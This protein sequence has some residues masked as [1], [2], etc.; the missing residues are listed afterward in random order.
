MRPRLNATWIRAALAVAVM[1]L[2]FGRVAVRDLPPTTWAV[3]LVPGESIDGWTVRELRRNPAQV[4]VDLSR[5]DNTRASLR[6]MHAASSPEGTRA[7]RYRIQAEV[8]APPSLVAEAAVRVTAWESE[9]PRPPAFVRA[10]GAQPS[11]TQRVEIILLDL[12]LAALV[13]VFVLLVPHL[14]RHAFLATP[15]RGAAL[16]ALAAVPGLLS[17]AFGTRGIWHSNH[18]GLDRWADLIA[19]THPAMA[20]LSLLH[21]GSFYLLHQLVPV[22]DPFHAATAL[23]GVAVVL[24][25]LWARALWDSDAAGL[26]AAALLAAAPLLVRVA[27]SE[28][29]YVPALA[30]LSATLLLTELWRRDARFAWGLLPALLLL[31]QSRGEML[32]LG[33]AFVGWCALARPPRWLRG[34]RDLLRPAVWAPPLL[35]G[36]ASIPRLM[37]FLDQPKRPNFSHAQD[38]VD[39]R[40]L[41][42]LGLGVAALLLLPKLRPRGRWAYGM[43][44]TGALASVLTGA[45][46]WFGPLAYIP[47][48]PLSPLLHPPTAL[49]LL[50]LAAAAGIALCARASNGR[51]AWLLGCVAGT[52]LVILP[53]YDCFSTWT[54]SNITTLPFLAA[55]AAP[56]I[57]AAGARVS[58]ALTLLVAAA[59]LLPLSSPLWQ[60]YP[61]QQLHELIVAARALPPDVQLVG[62]TPDDHRSHLPPP[63]MNHLLDLPH[64]LGRPV[65]SVGAWRS[66]ALPD[67]PTRFLITTDCWRLSFDPD[68]DLGRAW[69]DNL[70]VPWRYIG[71]PTS[72]VHPRISAELPEAAMPDPRCAAAID[73]ATEVHHREHTLPGNPGS[74]YETLFGDPPWLGIATIPAR[75]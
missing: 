45:W 13:A 63:V 61:K 37:S 43:V 34:A 66:G 67:A 31:T 74:V 57:A 8:D 3:P 39:P 15:A 6:L 35:L 19:G 44:A 62:L 29:M 53:H 9:W 17:A 59:G 68:A 41:L 12:A 55:L 21:G 49:P 36:L 11:T 58:P 24:V 48:A 1:L 4:F 32:A 65:Y 33:P 75:P 22:A 72:S 14:R 26:I 51:T 7:G 2:A 18:H 64:L 38:G 5:P 52:W 25:G 20:N 73:R 27:A 47:R 16:L 42:V 60:R 71:E 23:A 56:A 69:R 70:K 46:A 10:P 40:L 30:L 28:D 54:R 50:P